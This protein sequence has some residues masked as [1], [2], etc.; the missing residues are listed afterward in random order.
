MNGSGLP[1]AEIGELLFQLM[2][3]L[4]EPNC[5]ETSI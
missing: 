5:G 4:G 2:E 1:K 3:L